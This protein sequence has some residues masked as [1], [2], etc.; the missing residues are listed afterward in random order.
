MLRSLSGFGR[1]AVKAVSRRTFV[2]HLHQKS[3]LSR[4]GERWKAEGRRR[5]SSG[6]GDEAFGARLS[7]LLN[8]SAVAST[9][10]IAHKTG[11]LGAMIERAGT[12]H[13]A[14]EWSQA[15]G[16]SERYVAE[17]FGVLVSGKVVDMTTAGDGG[18][19]G[20]KRESFS[21]PDARAQALKGMGVYFQELPILHA[22]AFNRLCEAAKVMTK[23]HESCRGGP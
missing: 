20:G 16:V 19:G 12:S 2:A 5:M 1:G 11:L 22:C 7:S 10:G 9:I 18:G 3:H 6:G 23:S 13:T 14:A 4:A 17:M 8:E 21:L 15:S